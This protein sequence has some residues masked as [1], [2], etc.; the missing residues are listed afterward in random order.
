MPILTS[1][2]DRTLTVTPMSS[3]VCNKVDVWG[4]SQHPKPSPS[5]WQLSVWSHSGIFPDGGGIDCGGG[6]IAEQTT[7]KVGGSSGRWRR[8]IILPLGEDMLMPQSGM[9]LSTFCSSPFRHLF[10]T[11]HL[12]SSSYNFLPPSFFFLMC[13]L[14]L[15]LEISLWW[16]QTSVK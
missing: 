7:T 6:G 9:F 3:V 11:L 8:V 1:N 16:T 12:Q 15:A 2:R 5:S 13:P 4:E 14:F 10:V